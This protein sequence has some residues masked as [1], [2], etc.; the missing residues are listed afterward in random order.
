MSTG[1]LLIPIAFVLWKG[2]RTAYPRVHVRLEFK[3]AD[4]WIG[5]FWDRKPNYTTRHFER[6]VWVCVLPM[7]PIHFW[8]ELP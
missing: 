2:W 7:L 5:V 8:C 3:P 4:C 1:W 6:H